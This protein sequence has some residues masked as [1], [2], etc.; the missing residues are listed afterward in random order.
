MTT[1]TRNPT[2][3][4]STL[5]PPVVHRD[6]RLTPAQTAQ[7]Y[8]R[9]GLNVTPQPRGQKGGLTW[10]SN[11]YTRHAYG[12]LKEV[13]AGQVNVAVLTGRTS[14]NLFVIDCE[15]ETSLMHTIDQFRQRDLNVWAYRTSRGG[16]LWVFSADGEV[17]NLKLPDLEVR[18]KSNIVI[19]PP[20]VHPDGPIY[21]WIFQ[22]ESE[23][24][25]VLLD[26]I[27]WLVDEAGKPVKLRSR[28]QRKP[29]SEHAQRRY[30]IA[31]RYHLEDDPR[32]DKLSNRTLDYLEHGHTIPKGQRNDRFFAAGCDFNGCGFDIDETRNILVPIASQSGLGLDEIPKTLGSVYS[33]PRK[34]SR[35]QI[36][37]YTPNPQHWDYVDCYIEAHKPAGR[38]GETDYLVLQALLDRARLA[39]NEHGVFRASE[40]EL[41]EKAHRSRK[42]VRK[43]LKRLR[44]ASPPWIFQVDRDKTS[45]AKTWRFSDAVIHQGKDLYK[46]TP[47][48]LSHMGGLPQWGTFVQRR[49]AI[50][51]GRKRRSWD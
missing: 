21:Q 24:P 34:P 6:Q 44:D 50:G 17:D 51:S 45:K 11:Q 4:S 32:F 25:T 19:C 28:Q 38:T 22:E 1:I 13:F 27:D 33:R 43:A 39:A 41:A 30:A 31:E 12:L 7:E 20:S 42:T 5:I 10:Q 29:P 18:G 3:E 48:Q 35:P 8:Y 2:L 16:H 37:G 26:T 47:L 9:L 49:F 46:T 40:R 14:R 23:P 15:T 36:P